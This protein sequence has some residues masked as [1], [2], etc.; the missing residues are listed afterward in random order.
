M[1]AKQRAQ[2]VSS[3][4]LSSAPWILTH[5]S[6]GLQGASFI[7]TRKLG[8]VIYPRSCKQ[9]YLGFNPRLSPECMLISHIMLETA[10][11]SAVTGM[12]AFEEGWHLTWPHRACTRMSDGAQGCRKASLKREYLN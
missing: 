2:K 5:P 11:A 9:E 1:T 6:E 3:I 10:R 8:N 7:K 12:V 4:T